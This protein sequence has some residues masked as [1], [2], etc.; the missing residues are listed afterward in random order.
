MGG[1]TGGSSMSWGLQLFG[2][3]FLLPGTTGPMQCELA[4]VDQATIC[5]STP[6]NISHTLIQLF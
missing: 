6:P 4:Q 5:M 3:S 1:V 2:S